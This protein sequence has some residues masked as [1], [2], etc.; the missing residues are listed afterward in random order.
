MKKI[1]IVI[2]FLFIGLMGCSSKPDVIHY[3][4]SYSASGDNLVYVINHGWHTGFVIPSTVL[5]QKLPELKNRFGN[6][7]YLEIG[8]GDKGFYQAK[9]I[10]TGLTLRAIF[11]PTESVMHVVSVSE[12]IEKAFLQSDTAVLYLTDN[13]LNALALFISGSFYFDKQKN[14]VKLKRGL[15]GNS[16]FYQAVGDY[17]MFNTCNKWTAKGLKSFG[18]DIMTTFKLSAS[19][20][21]E[22]LK[23]YKKDIAEEPSEK[24]FH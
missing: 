15:Y 21:M 19:S 17:Y 22:Y 24:V 2:I 18:M 20:I 16:Q 23:D 14:I 4:A 11:W 5:Y 12:D 10:T 9:E 1:Q 3:N 6:T 13:E 8:W 7:P